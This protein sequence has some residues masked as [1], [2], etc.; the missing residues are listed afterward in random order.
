M[1]K[2]IARQNCRAVSLDFTVYCEPRSFI[3]KKCFILFRLWVMNFKLLPLKASWRIPNNRNACTVISITILTLPYVCQEN[4]WIGRGNSS[5]LMALLLIFALMRLFSGYW[6]SENI[7]KRELWR[8]ALTQ[9]KILS[10][11]AEFAKCVLLSLIEP[12]TR[13]PW[14]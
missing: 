4:Q 2:M 10:T 13:V 9:T 6:V 1:H 3:Y 8:S 14:S 12:K 7:A 5:D 11:F